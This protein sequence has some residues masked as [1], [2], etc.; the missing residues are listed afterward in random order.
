MQG[1]TIAVREKVHSFTVFVR[2]TQDANRTRV[3][4]IYDSDAR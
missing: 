2:R 3:S 1:A 4:L